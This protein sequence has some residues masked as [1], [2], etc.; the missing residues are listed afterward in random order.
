MEGLVEDKER[1]QRE[2]NLRKKVKDGERIKKKEWGGEEYQID[3]L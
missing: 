3:L 2:T 1:Q